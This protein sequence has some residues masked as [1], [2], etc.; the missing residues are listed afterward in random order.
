MGRWQLP[1]KNKKPQDRSAEEVVAIFF[2]AEAAGLYHV[3]TPEER[4]PQTKLDLP[5]FLTNEDHRER[6]AT[7]GFSWGISASER[8]F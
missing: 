4:K 8:G 2:K 3:D 6:F 7:A 5:P 1:S